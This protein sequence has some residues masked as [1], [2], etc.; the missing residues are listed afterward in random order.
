ML[1]E[2]TVEGLGWLG[3]KEGFLE[4]TSKLASPF[5]IWTSQECQDQARG[6]VVKVHQRR[7]TEGKRVPQG[8]CGEGGVIM[9]GTQNTRKRRARGHGR[10]LSKGLDYKKSGWG[11]LNFTPSGLGN[12]G[13]L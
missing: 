9:S 4:V 2:Y 12:S 11:S 6:G 7:W 10:Y 8:W 13:G 5:W 1:S 3:S